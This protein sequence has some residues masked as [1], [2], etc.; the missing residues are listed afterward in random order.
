M[1]P[2][3][4][5]G[6]SMNERRSNSPSSNARSERHGAF[7]LI[8]MTVALSV[9]SILLLAIGSAM[10][11][12]SRAI[13]D[14]EGPVRAA[15]EGGEA[16]TR[17]RTELRHALYIAERT[18]HAI[19]FTVADRTGNG[20]PERIRYAWS[21]QTGDPLTRQLN[22]ESA[23]EIISNVEAFALRY[24]LHETEERY[25]GP[26]VLGSERV[27]SRADS[28]LGL[29]TSEHE[30]RSDQWVAQYVQPTFEDEVRWWQPTRLRF[31]ARKHSS[32]DGEYR[33]ELRRTDLAYVP[34]DRILT[35]TIRQESLLGTLLSEREVSF[36]DPPRLLPGTPLALVFGHESGPESS[37]VVEHYENTDIGGLSLGDGDGA[38]QLQSD[39][40]LRHTLYGRP[41]RASSEQR[42]ARRFITAVDTHL[43]TSQPSQAVI[44]AQ[45][46]LTNQ[47]EALRGLWY[48]DFEH[49]PT[50]IDVNADM[51]PDWS[52]G[53]AFD[54]ST[55]EDGV[56][57][58]NLTL[59][60]QP[61]DALNTPMRVRLRL[62]HTLADGGGALV[63]LHFDRT[64]GTLGT[65]MPLVQRQSDGTQTLILYSRHDDGTWVPLRRVPGLPPDFVDL[66]LLIDPELETAHLRVNHEDKG[67]HP[68]ELQ[69]ATAGEGQILLSHSGPN[70]EYEYVEVAL[71]EAF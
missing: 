53:A 44:N 42:F 55:L 52:A 71:S 8:E 67:T 32:S 9:T 35:A 49:D 34:D 25:P 51:E 20:S 22:D 59:G 45:V 12:T 37:A 18:E 17:F 64:D 11:L 66:R 68:Y 46:E 56:W 33:V 43:R 63:R 57:H 19:T 26:A 54:S 48:A 31:H 30:I 36:E 23:V 4:Q 58:A 61:L 7:S 15:I 27:L 29:A 2:Y 40:T 39:Q 1:N 69:S 16:L 24:H 70:A 60:A 65:L 3:A 47:P 50:A 13:P 21:G 38:W 6:V 5:P 14:G 10:M 41:A 62:R 28:L